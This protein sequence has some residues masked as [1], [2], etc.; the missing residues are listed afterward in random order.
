MD[1]YAVLGVA[2]NATPEEI[3]KAYRK[4]ASQHHPDKGGDTNK[5]QEIQTAYDTLSD[6]QKRAMYDNP[7]PQGFPGGFSFNMGPGMDFNDIFGQMFAQ[8]TGTPFG[9]RNGRQIM[10][11]Q[12]RV[13]LLDAYT[14]SNQVLK[15]NT[16]QGLKVVDITIPK[17]VQSGQQIR[18]DN[19]LPGATLLVEFLVLQ[20]LQ[21]ERQGDNLYSNQSINVLDLIA[22]TKFDFLTISNKMVTVNVPAKTQ[23]FMHLKLNGQ[24]M[25]IGDTGHYG[26]QL[27]LLKPYIPDNISDDIVDAILRNRGN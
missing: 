22:G 27:I 13:S 5:F 4:L 18:Y 24:G 23:P 8:G 15:I 16:Q 11:T 17:G 10:R 7:Q 1:H 12:L 25:P 3:K 19:V 14:G 26:D 20:H 6:P 2:K 21:Y 9:P